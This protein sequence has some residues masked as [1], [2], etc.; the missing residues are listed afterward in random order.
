LA[1]AT[2][3]RV[4]C[5]A[6]DSLRQSVKIKMF[7]S[8]FKFHEFGS[9]VSVYQCLHTLV[10]SLAVL[11]ALTVYRQAHRAVIRT[12]AQSQPVPVSLPS[13]SIST[14]S[15]CLVSCRPDRKTCQILETFASHSKMKTRNSIAGLHTIQQ[16]HFA[17][18]PTVHHRHVLYVCS[19]SVS[20]INASVPLPPLFMIVM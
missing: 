1:L 16:H 17:N 20:P 3:A 12:P 8:C 9:G 11:T 19:V 6:S 15:I 2:I 5:S 18:P 14:V 4:F 13:G 7:V 10:L